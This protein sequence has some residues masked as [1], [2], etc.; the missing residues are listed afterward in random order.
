M[1]QGWPWSAAGL[2][3]VGTAGAQ[4]RTVMPGGPAARA[5]LQPGDRILA[6]DGAPVSSPAQLT[7]LVERNGVGR[8]MA[9]RL[10]RQGQPITVQVMPAEL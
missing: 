5:G 1:A 9:L 4:V 10:D 7:Q 6:V 3:V 2:A 8:P